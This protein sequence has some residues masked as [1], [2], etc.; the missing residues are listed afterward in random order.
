MMYEPT[1]EEVEWFEA[2]QDKAAELHEMSWCT[3][4]G[5]IRWTAS[6]R[7][8]ECLRCSDF[9]ARGGACDPL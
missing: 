7:A 8:R 3:R 5:W 6:L 2:T 1:E 9:I 4:M